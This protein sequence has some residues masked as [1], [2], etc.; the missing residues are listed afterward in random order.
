VND[1]H[2][3]KAE[4]A[5][6]SAHID[7]VLSSEHVMGPTQD[8]F[9]RR[10]AVSAQLAQAEASIEI[11]RQLRAMNLVTMSTDM[12][13]TRDVSDTPAEMVKKWIAFM[14]KATPIIDEILDL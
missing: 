8:A 7:V 6:D 3:E 11:A 13:T 10:A 1:S 12:I 4:R 2:I 5:I 9:L 14:E